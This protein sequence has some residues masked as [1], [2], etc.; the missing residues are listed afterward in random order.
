MTGNA[1]GVEDTV[2]TD[3][4]STVLATDFVVTDV[5]P[6]TATVQTAV[7]EKHYLLLVRF[8]SMI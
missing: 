3:A 6:V 1:D 5:G 4:W 2:G 8:I 7:A